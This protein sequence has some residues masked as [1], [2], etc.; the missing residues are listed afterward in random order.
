MGAHD[1][2]APSPL[3]PISVPE[4]NHGRMQFVCTLSRSP[5]VVKG[6]VWIEILG[7]LAAGVSLGCRN[8]CN[9]ELGTSSPGYG[10]LWCNVVMLQVES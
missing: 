7:R 9:H 10:Q 1:A 4:A 3:L 6:S 2:C 5:A 8:Y